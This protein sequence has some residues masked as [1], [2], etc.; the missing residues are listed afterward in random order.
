MVCSDGMGAGSSVGILLGTMGMGIM[1]R[2][3][4]YQHRQPGRQDGL[5]WEAADC[6]IVSCLSIS[7]ISSMLSVFYA[8]ITLHRLM[9]ASLVVTWATT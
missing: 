7:F 1:W 8:M 4:G 2:R 9:T 6:P 5:G 3:H